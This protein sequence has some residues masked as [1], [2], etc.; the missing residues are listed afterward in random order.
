MS[1]T[2][3]G[4]DF[5]YRVLELVLGIKKLDLQEDEEE[6]TKQKSV[7]ISTSLCLFR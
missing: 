5:A 6:T 7:C 3:D 2:L 1:T 4:N